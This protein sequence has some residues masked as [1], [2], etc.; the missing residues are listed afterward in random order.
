MVATLSEAKLPRRF[1][2]F[3]HEPESSAERDKA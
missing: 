1:L 3:E 2:M